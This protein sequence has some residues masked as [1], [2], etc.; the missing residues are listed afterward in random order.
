MA[1]ALTPDNG[2]Y[3]L[4]AADGGVFSFHAPFFGSEGGTH[5]AARVVGITSAQDGDGYRLVAADGG[6]FDFGVAN[7]AGSRGG[8]HLNAPIV[9]AA[10]L[11][12]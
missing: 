11:E 9:A 6:L 8:Q 5:L 10:S 4:V 2:G 7:F 1:I 3:W 12:A